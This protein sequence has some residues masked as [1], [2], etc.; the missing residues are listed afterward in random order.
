MIRKYP[1]GFTFIEILLAMAILG[2]GLVS[3]LTIFSAGARSVKKT[4]ENTEASFI[5]QMDLENFRRLGHTT[6][7]SITSSNLVNLST[8]TPHY[9]SSGYNHS[10]TASMVTGNAYINNLYLVNLTVTRSGSNNKTFTTYIA[11]YET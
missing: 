6:L 5:A 4:L 11:L 7:G 10:V 1:R 3:I 9:Y 2:I 8:E